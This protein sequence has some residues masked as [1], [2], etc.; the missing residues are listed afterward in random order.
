MTTNHHFSFEVPGQPVSWNHMYVAVRN[1][2]RALVKTRDAVAYQDTVQILCKAARPSSFH[3]QHTV[4]VGYR[5][6]LVKDVD[7]DNLMKATNDAVAR[8]LGLDDRYFFP[9]ALG[10][11]IVY[12][13][14]R[15][16]ISL[17]DADTWQVTMVP[18]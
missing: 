15:T 10:K 4:Y 7:C 13:N 11:D 1:R 5:F 17:W 14:P 16:V 8:A 12:S 6:F 3:P 18:R 9:L 2:P